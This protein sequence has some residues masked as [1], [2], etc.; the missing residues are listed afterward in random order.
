MNLNYSFQDLYNKIQILDS[1][2]EIFDALKN[3]KE[4]IKFF[5]Q[6][7]ES[8]KEFNI[9]NISNFPAEIDWELYAFS[10][11]NDLLLTPFQAK[12]KNNDL[13]ELYEKFMDSI[14]LH[15]DI[16]KR[17]FQPIYHEIVRVEQSAIPT[18][19]PTVISYLWPTTVFGELIISR[20]GI[21]VKSGSDFINKT[22]A[23][24]SKLFW[25]YQRKYKE[26]E[27]LSAGWGSNSQ[28][29]TSFRKDYSTKIHN[30]YNLGEK[31]F[32]DLNASNISIDKNI[33]RDIEIDEAIELVKNRC[34]IKYNKP[35]DNLWPYKFSYVEEKSK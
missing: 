23:E 11:V 8:I 17:E 16:S 14:G 9:N 1:Y 30:Y 26:T 10:R 28:W 2:Y 34:F 20:G 32:I 5:F 29:R 4:D 13:R 21:V 19:E 7:I 25:T 15:I 35:S 6:K 18:E 3:E 27:D 12:E 33:L 31:N 22:I 24:N